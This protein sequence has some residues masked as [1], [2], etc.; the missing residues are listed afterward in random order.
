MIKTCSK[1]SRQK[2]QIQHLGFLD[3]EQVLKYNASIQSP[4]LFSHS[5]QQ[6]RFPECTKLVLTSKTKLLEINCID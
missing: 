6:Q 5:T 3:F 4:K 1:I 2:R